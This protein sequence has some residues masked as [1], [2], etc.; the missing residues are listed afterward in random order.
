MPPPPARAAG[1]CG[2]TPGA[3]PA[4]EPGRVE[5]AAGVVGVFVLSGFGLDQHDGVEPSAVQ[6]QPPGRR[7]ACLSVRLHRA[8]HQPRLAVGADRRRRR[9]AVRPEAALADGA[10]HPAVRR[11]ATSG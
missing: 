4:P 7:P 10:R 9:Q 2:R 5:Y 11:P 3:P 1:L 6:R 8:D